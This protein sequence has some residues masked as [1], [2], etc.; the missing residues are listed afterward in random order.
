MSY[1]KVVVLLKGIARLFLVIVLLVN[2]FPVR[3]QFFEFNTKRKRVTIPFILVKNLLIIPITINGKGPFN[4]ILDSGVGIAV[5]TDSKLIDSIG[6]ENVRS[7]AIA[8]FGER[9]DISAYIAP[10]VEYS[11]IPSIRGRITTAILK[12]DSFDLSSFTGMPIHGLIGYEFFNSFI[13]RINFS[14]HN[15]TIYPKDANYILKKGYKIPITIEDHK[16]YLTTDLVLDSG[17]KLNVKLIIDTGAGHPLWLETIGGIPVEIPNRRIH[18]NLG[19]GLAGKIDGY[20]GRIPSFRFGKYWLKDVIASF[21]DYAHAGAKIQSFNRNGNIGNGVLRKFDLVFDYN[22]GALYLRPNN[23][24]KER[25][26][27]DMSGIEF[28]SAGEN[29]KRIIVSR[30]EPGSAAEE[31]GIEENDEIMSINFKSVAEMSIDEIDGLFKSQDQR[32]F[33]LM[34]G[35]KGSNQPLRIILELKRRI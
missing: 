23:S 8:G 29:F 24:F 34:I 1:L 28:T 5:I 10:S 3:G 18:A 31:A 4:F 9:K 6:L 30:V 26:D 7:V 32:S 14:T 33:L 17:K 20:I 27:H 19:V 13:V 22:R 2:S 16:P 15:I 21:P 25:F 12:S 35:R 11:L